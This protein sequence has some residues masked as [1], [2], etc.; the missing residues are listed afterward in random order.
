MGCDLHAL[1]GL[2]LHGR[3][4]DYLWA[5]DWDVG[6]VGDLAAILHSYSTT[7]VDLLSTS[8][9]HQFT[10]N[11]TGYTQFE[12]RTYLSPTEV[13]R[14]L[15]APA[16]YSRRLLTAMDE[17]VR[18]GK[19]AFCETRAPSLCTAQGWCSQQSMQTVNPSLLVEGYGC[20]D[21]FG[22]DDLSHF[23]TAWAAMPPALRPP[24]QLVHRL[25]P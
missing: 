6:W 20:C 13:Y 9:A 22:E 11:Q 16:R 18:S 12:L 24:G 25:R 14:A 5:V 23:Q 2:Q 3:H 15:L 8:P 17:L 1:V 19:Q 7:P 21:D 4:V 10:S